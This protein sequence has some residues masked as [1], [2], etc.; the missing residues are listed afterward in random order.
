MTPLRD[1]DT[2]SCCVLSSLEPVWMMMWLGEPSCSSDSSSMAC[3]LVGHHSFDTLWLGNSFFSFKN[4]PLESMR[5]TMSA[6]CA[7]GLAG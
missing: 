3:R 6:C 5:M 4:F 2:L 1:S 7:G